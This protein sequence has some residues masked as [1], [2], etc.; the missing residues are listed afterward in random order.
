MYRSGLNGM[1]HATGPRMQHTRPLATT[2]RTRTQHTRPL[3]S[4][5]RTMTQQHTMPLAITRRTRT[6]QTTMPLAITRRTRTQQHTLPLAIIRRK[7][8]APRVALGV[9]GHH[10]DVYYNKLIS[11]MAFNNVGEISFESDLFQATPHIKPPF[12]FSS[13]QSSRQ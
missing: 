5:R 2:R 12:Q 10:L 8:R 1:P 7:Q 9:V 11:N 13:V 4:T 3:A 6:Q